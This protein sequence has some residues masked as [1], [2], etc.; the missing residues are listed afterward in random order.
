MR[1]RCRILMT[2]LSVSAAAW[3]ITACRGGEVA[4][5]GTY[6]NAAIGAGNPVDSKGYTLKNKSILW[7]THRIHVCWER[8]STGSEEDKESIRQAV[9]TDY[10]RTA[11][12]GFEGIKFVGWSICSPG[13]REG[14]RILLGDHAAQ[15]RALGAF[16]SGLRNGM[17]LFDSTHANSCGVDSRERKEKCIRVTAIHEFG[18]AL[19]LR[20]E[21]ERLTRPGCPDENAELKEKMDE[22]GFTIGPYDPDSIMNYCNVEWTSLSQG[23]IEALRQ[24]YSNRIPLVDRPNHPDNEKLCEK[25]VL[26]YD[27]NLLRCVYDADICYRQGL[28]F[29]NDPSAWIGC[30]AIETKEECE[31]VP[32][33]YSPKW[34]QAE[35]W[36]ITES[37]DTQGT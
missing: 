17:L 12:K 10:S 18:H 7:Q 13:D 5:G 23:D 37:P 32:A 15:V 6:P 19:G 24:L 28:Y 22:E 14:I 34:D 4:D 25:F 20:H 27:P 1:Y 33:S 36:C 3:A 21:Q 29:K 26:G 31:K 30:M 9:L 35:M 8:E 2:A 16:M 11:T